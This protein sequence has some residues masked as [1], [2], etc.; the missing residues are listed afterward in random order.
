MHNALSG[1]AKLQ[2]AALPTLSAL[3]ELIMRD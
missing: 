2:P 3:I 1:I